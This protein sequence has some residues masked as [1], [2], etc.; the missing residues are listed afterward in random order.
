MR[1]YDGRM[2]GCISDWTA[3]TGPTLTLHLSNDQTHIYTLGADNKVGV[4]IHFPL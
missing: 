1:V 2:E 3:H 4:G